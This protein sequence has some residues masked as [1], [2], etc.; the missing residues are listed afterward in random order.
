MREE[1]R[2]DTWQGLVGRYNLVGE[3]RSLGIKT[4]HL[5]GNK[6]L[7]MASLFYIREDLLILDSYHLRNNF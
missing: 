2:F 5:V 4:V 1:R 6:G 3:E 7:K